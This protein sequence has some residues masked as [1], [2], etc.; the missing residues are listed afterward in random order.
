VGDPRDDG[1]QHLVYGTRE[2]DLFDWKVQGNPA[3]SDWPHYRGDTF[4]DGVYRG[5]AGSA[6]AASRS[7]RHARA[8]RGRVRGIEG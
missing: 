7:V 1:Q 6:P 5:A 8:G 4:N 3:A 2:G